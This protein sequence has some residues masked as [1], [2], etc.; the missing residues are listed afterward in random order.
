MCD[1]PLVVDNIDSSTITKPFV[2]YFG[3]VVCNNIISV[4]F[5]ND[6]LD[7]RMMGDLD[8][9]DRCSLR[10]AC[11]YYQHQYGVNPPEKFPYSLSQRWYA[12]MKCYHSV[13]VALLILLLPVINGFLMQNI[14]SL[15]FPF[16]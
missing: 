11:V 13:I 5:K 2:A 14:G 15:Q 16:I 3:R 8:A 4:G 12:L 6:F 9:S 10:G 1:V 7:A